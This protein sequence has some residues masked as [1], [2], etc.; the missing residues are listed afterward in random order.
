MR[1][2]V[3]ICCLKTIQAVR[4][5]NFNGRFLFFVENEVNSYKY[6]QQNEGNVL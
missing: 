1:R 4:R 5:I 2:T 6:P 3:W